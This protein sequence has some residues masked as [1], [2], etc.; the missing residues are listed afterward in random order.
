MEYAKIT[1]NRFN[2]R[3]LI[4]PTDKH[5]KITDEIKKKIDKTMESK[6]NHKINT[7]VDDTIKEISFD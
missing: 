4:I 6:Y 5:K 7:T 3:V 2:R 1:V